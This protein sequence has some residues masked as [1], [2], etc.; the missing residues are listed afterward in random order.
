MGT[1]AVIRL[2]VPD[3]QIGSEVSVYFKDTMLKKGTCER[4]EDEHRHGNWEPIWS[5]NVAESVRCSVC[6][7]V[8]KSPF[9]HYCRWCG[10]EMYME[11]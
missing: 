2:D 8:S 1:K 7:K 10:A 11:E 6:W 4:Y 5:G 9:G 3:W